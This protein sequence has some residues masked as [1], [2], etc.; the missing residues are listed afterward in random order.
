[1]KANT[2]LKEEALP[3]TPPAQNKYAWPNATVEDY[4]FF[5]LSDWYFLADAVMLLR[6]KRPFMHGNELRR[7]IDIKNLGDQMDAMNRY[8]QESE[9]LFSSSLFVNLISQE[10]LQKRA[11]QL[12]HTEIKPQ[13]LL[14]LIV[15][16]RIA[17]LPPELIKALKE[18]E[19][20]EEA[21]KALRI[22][23]TDLAVQAWKRFLIKSKNPVLMQQIFDKGHEIAKATPNMLQSRLIWN[24]KQEK[25]TWKGETNSKQVAISTLKE[26]AMH[27][28]ALL[29][30]S[31]SHSKKK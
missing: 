6:G 9:A 28:W 24:L 18:V 8:R 10:N 2:K 20:L 16:K 17:A 31:K 4:K 27:I 13:Q 1:M 26:V 11:N 22:I 29:G 23:D 25:F 15:E 19:C 14:K 30:R 12:N 7:I 5:L 21:K 3:P